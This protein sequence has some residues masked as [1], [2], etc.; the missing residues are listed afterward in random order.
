MSGKNAAGGALSGAASGAALGSVV[1]GIGT[2]IGA[3]GGGL[4]GLFGGMF[5]GDD[6]A[7]NQLR[8]NQQ[9]YGSLQAPTFQNYNPVA[10]NPQDATATQIQEDPSTRSAQQNVLNRMAGLANTGLSDVDNAGFERARELGNQMS[11]SGTQAAMQNAQARGVGGSGL[12]FAMREMAGQQGAQRAQDAGLQQAATSAQQRAM[13]NQA[14]GQGLQNLRGQDFNANSANANILNQFNAMNTQNRNQ[15][16]QYNVGQ[17]NYA[18][19]YANDIKQRQYQDQLQR[20]AGMSN[21]NSGVANQYNAQDA[22]NQSALNSGMAAAGTVGMGLYAGRD[23]SPQVSTAAPEA[24]V[25]TEDDPFG[26]GKKESR[27][28]TYGT[29]A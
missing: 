2:A 25:Q 1:P 20:A 27:Y 19:Q 26:V 21:A 18:Q 5:G 8:A 16:Q 29:Y 9:L 24:K 7:M 13:Y 10:Y 23:K 28:S 22:A 4:A 14:Y 3:I 17:Q 6:D 15:A 11:N 12:E